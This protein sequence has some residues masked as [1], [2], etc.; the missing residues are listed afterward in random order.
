[1]YRQGTPSN[2]TRLTYAHFFPPFL[3]FG[4]A[5]S[6]SSSDLFTLL[7]TRMRSLQH[8]KIYFTV[9]LPSLP[10]H[11][12]GRSEFDVCPFA[13]IE[14]RLPAPITSVCQLHFAP[15]FP[16][17][18]RSSTGTTRPQGKNLI[19]WKTKTKRVARGAR[20]IE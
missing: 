12:Y 19:G 14:T 15:T 5:C 13:E 2:T 8:L 18:S 11:H 4:C 20:A 10:S 7:L 9:F 17:N 3:E 16:F 6:Q 1:M